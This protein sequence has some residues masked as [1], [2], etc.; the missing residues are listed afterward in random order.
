MVLEALAKSGTQLMDRAVAVALAVAI[1]LHSLPTVG[2][3]P[4]AVFMVVLEAVA[5]VIAAAVRL[6]VLVVTVHRACSRSLTRQ[7]VVGQHFVF[8][9][10]WV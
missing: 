3:V 8:A 6:A 9:A 10:S 4:L 1:T 5:E 2:T 7:A